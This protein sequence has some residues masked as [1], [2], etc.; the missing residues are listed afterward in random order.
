MAHSGSICRL[1]TLNF[2]RLLGLGK[3]YRNTF[4]ERSQYFATIEIDGPLRS[5]GR[6]SRLT[7]CSLHLS[8][9]RRRAAIWRAP[10]LGESAAGRPDD[11]STA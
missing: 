6:G 4:G 7:V 2:A 3:I 1:L 10:G 9:N 5:V 11:A 8:A